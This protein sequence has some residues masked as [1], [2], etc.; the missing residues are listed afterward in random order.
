[1]NCSSCKGCEERKPGCH[2]SCRR[3]K[4]YCILN[5]VKK[6]REQEIARL[7]A[8]DAEMRIRN[9]NAFRGGARGVLHGK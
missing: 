4:M 8:Y 5:A 7:K 6:A 3:Y 9:N 1:M 2:D